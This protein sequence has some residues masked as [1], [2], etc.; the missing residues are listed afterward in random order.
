[1]WK[2]LAFGP[3]IVTTLLL[4]VTGGGTTLPGG[5]IPIAL[6]SSAVTGLGVVL[7][8]KIVVPTFAYN[9][10]KDRADKWE[11]E[12]IRLNQTIADRHVPALDA[13]SHAITKSSEV[14][15]RAIETFGRRKS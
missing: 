5:S 12:V 8:G 2:L 6:V 3:P 11:T 10:E 15:E 14:V 1:V 7:S 13:A 4:A 9:R